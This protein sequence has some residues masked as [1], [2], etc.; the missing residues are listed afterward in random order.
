MTA[1]GA[2]IP[3]SQVASIRQDAGESTITHEMG[4]RHLTVKLDLR[5]RDLS[6][7]IGDAKDRIEKE[8]AYDH[9]RYQVEWG[10]AFENQQRAEARLAVIC[11][12]RWR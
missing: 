9:Q 3:L 6:T 12:R 8:V 4:R 5:G 10:G 2:R 11:P 1:S 7:F